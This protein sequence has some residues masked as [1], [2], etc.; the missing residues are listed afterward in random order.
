MPAFDSAVRSW[1]VRPPRTKM[2][3]WVRRSAPADSV[4]LMTGRRFSRA[5]WQ[6]AQRLGDRVRVGRPTLDGRVGAADVA[7]DA[8]DASDPGDGGPAGVEVGPVPDQRLDLEERASHGRAAA[9]AV[10]AASSLPRPRWRSTFAGPP[11]ARA[12]ANASSSSASSA[13]L[14]SRLRCACSVGT[15][16]TGSRARRSPQEPHVPPP[17]PRLLSDGHPHPANGTI[18]QRTFRSGPGHRQRG[19]SWGARSRRVGLR[20]SAADTVGSVTGH[21]TP[22][23][24]SSQAMPRLS[25]SGDQYPPTS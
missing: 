11:P 19:W 4:R 21:A 14:A 5:I 8:V 23:S 16:R 7:L 2:S 1:K 20:R 12:S 22:R 10:R 18:A 25:T 15:R 24:G 13:R 3:F 6:P 9:R 17:P